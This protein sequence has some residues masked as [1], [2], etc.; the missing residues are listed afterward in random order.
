MKYSPIGS[1]RAFVP[2]H[3][4]GQVFVELTEDTTIVFSYL[5]E[6]RDH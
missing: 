2:N 5:V 4:C 1:I 6:T 3:F